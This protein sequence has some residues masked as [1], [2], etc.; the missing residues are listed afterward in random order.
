MTPLMSQTYGYRSYSSS[1]F[2]QNVNRSNSLFTFWLISSNLAARSCHSCIWRQDKARVS[3]EKQTKMEPKAIE[4]LLVGYDGDERY[5]LYVSKQRKVNVS[6]DVRLVLE[7]ITVL[8]RV[9]KQRR[10]LMLLMS[11]M[12]AESMKVSNQ[13]KQMSLIA[14]LLWGEDKVVEKTTKQ[15]RELHDCSKLYISAQLQDCIFV[16]NTEDPDKNK[17]SNC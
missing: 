2:T 4:G 7:M 6:R 9:S 16:C 11:L 5:R 15:E 13:R 10:Q 8:M 3:H 14:Q 12:I 17:K 1:L